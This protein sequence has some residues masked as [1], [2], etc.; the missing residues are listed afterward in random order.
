MPIE[1]LRIGCGLQC[2]L[3]H[4]PLVPSSRPLLFS[5]AVKLLKFAMGCKGQCTN[6]PVEYA[7]MEAMYPLLCSPDE[8]VLSTL[9]SLVLALLEGKTDLPI[10]GVFGAGKTRSAAILMV[11][12]LV[13]EPN[14]NL[15]VLTKENV[16]AQAFAEHIEGLNMP[17]CVNAK[18]GRL[19]GYMELKKNRTKG[20]SLD[21]TSENRHEVLKQKRLLIGC[22][23]GFQHTQYYRELQ[24]TT[25]VL[26]YHSSTT[27]CYSVLQSATL[28]YKAPPRYYKVLLRTTKF[29]SSKTLYYTV[30]LQD[31][32]VLLRYY[33]VLLEVLLCT[34]KFCSSTTLYYKVLLQYYRVFLCTTKYYSS[35]TLYYKVRLQYYKSTTK[36]CRVLLRTTQSCYFT[37][38]L[39]YWSLCIFNSP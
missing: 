37:E 25:P 9:G 10:S 14:L 26:Q 20:T 32:K 5:A 29:Y 31:Y 38:L 39:L 11:G 3:P 35:T 23:G 22:G 24:S 17:P 28:Y 2:T 12:L 7:L 1:R 13:F 8:H 16:A 19:V 15:M 34:R 18:I 30:L 21:V 33:K 6:N 27:K 4:V 36:Y